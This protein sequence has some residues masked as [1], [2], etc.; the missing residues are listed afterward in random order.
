MPGNSIL[1]Y[2]QSFF[3]GFKLVNADELKTLA[4]QLFSVT[5]GLTAHA[6]G[7]QAASLPMPAA[8]NNVTTVASANDSVQLPPA[9]IG[10]QIFLVN[11]GA[12]SMQV[13]GDPSNLANGNASDVIIPHNSNNAAAA[14]TGV[15]QASTVGA[16]YVCVTLGVWKQL[17]FS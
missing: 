9:L 7:G 3:G 2:F 5:S 6:G 13:F 11:A 14:G 8:I 4:N 17:L 16:L 1:S 15:A 12:N 10:A